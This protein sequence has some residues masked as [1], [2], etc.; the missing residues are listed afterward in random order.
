MATA[1]RLFNKFIGGPGGATEVC[2]F[3]LREIKTTEDKER[4][5]LHER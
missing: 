1:K 3:C 5:N 4:G 2:L